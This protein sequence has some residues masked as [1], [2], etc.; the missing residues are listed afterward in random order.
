MKGFVK[1]LT[2]ILGVLA[3]IA[4]LATIGIIG[5]SIMN[6]GATLKG[7]NPKMSAQPTGDSL[8]EA[9]V[10]EDLIPVPTATPVGSDTNQVP[11]DL[12]DHVHDYKES[13]LKKATCYEPGRLQY[14]CEGCGDIYYVDILSTGHVADE[15][16]VVL[17]EATNTETGTRVRKCIYCDEIVFSEVIPVGGFRE[18]GATPVPSH[19]HQ[20]I[21]STER[22]ATCT[23]AG[24]RKHTCTC[25]NFYTESIP[26]L[27]HIATVW[28]E[29]EAASATTMGREQRTCTVCGAVL[30]TR[31]I[32]M[33]APS[34]SA[35]TSPSASAAPS[36]SA[37]AS[38]S[39]SGGASSAP[40]ETEKPKPSATPS[41]TPH[42]HMYT[43]YVLKTATCT[44]KGIRSFVC[45]CGSS[46]AEAIELDLENH[47]YSAIVIPPGETTQG[48]TIFTCTRCNFTYTDNF[49]P[50]L[51]V[52]N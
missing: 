25:G 5:Y 29:V 22:E 51:S 36:G 7:E 27:G 35:G 6:P 13:I 38:A 40:K 10:D 26:A 9:Q 12:S 42:S 15:E 28:T 14:T 18:P 34:P 24:L 4:C 49:V 46:Y 43:A 47:H 31:T 8:E 48:Y 20:Y 19:T 32:P 2:G 44:E 50:A 37:A 16:W 1:F 23:M 45:T 41:P 17:K 39:A 3:A 11:V 30:D 33:L 21:A 52:S